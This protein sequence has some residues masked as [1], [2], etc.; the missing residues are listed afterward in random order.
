[1]RI[2]IYAFLVSVF[3]RT[4]IGSALQVIDQDSQCVIWSNDNHRYTGYS[5][6]F[7]KLKEDDYSGKRLQATLSYLQE[8]VNNFLELSE[9]VNGK[10]GLKKK[11]I[12]LV[13]SRSN[14]LRLIKFLFLTP[15]GGSTEAPPTADL[16]VLW[17]RTSIR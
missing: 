14:S 5:A 7:G 17:A 16:L 10:H 11:F 1:M 2:K 6:P 3:I 13:P 9:I 4:S 8:Y 15:C 12:I